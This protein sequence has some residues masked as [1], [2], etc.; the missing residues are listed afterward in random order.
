ME[1]IEPNSHAMIRTHDLG[2]DD[3]RD[4]EEV[5]LVSRRSSSGRAVTVELDSCEAVVVLARV[6]VLVG[7]L[8]SFSRFWRL[9]W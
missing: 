7:C 4:A 3:G 6:A 5:V 1:L 9:A 2:N 8:H